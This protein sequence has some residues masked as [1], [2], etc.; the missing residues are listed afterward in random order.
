METQAKNVGLCSLIET[1]DA[2]F[3]NCRIEHLG[4]FE[5][6]CETSLVSESGH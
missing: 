3:V 1:V 5:A 2:D 4:E 6:I